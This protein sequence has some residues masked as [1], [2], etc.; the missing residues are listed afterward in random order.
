[1]LSQAEIALFQCR[2]C[3]PNADSYMEFRI[4]IAGSSNEFEG[5]LVRGF[6]VGIESEEERQYFSQTFDAESAKHLRDFLNY[7]LKDL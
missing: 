3:E 2:E 1:M 5:F 7:A 6:R 4:D